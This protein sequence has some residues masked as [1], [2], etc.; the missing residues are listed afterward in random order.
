MPASFM[1]RH[2]TICAVLEEIRSEAYEP[3]MT[4]DRFNALID[5]A[6]GYAQSMS[7]KLTKNKT[8]ITRLVK[9]R[10]AALDDASRLR[11]PDTTGQ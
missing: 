9:E 3:D 1:K 8:D 11:Y 2:R 6:K 4:L 7:A 10:D 5:E